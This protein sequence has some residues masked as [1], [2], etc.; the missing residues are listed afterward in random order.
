MD[1]IDVEKIVGG[2]LSHEDIEKLDKEL[3]EEQKAEVVQKATGDFKETLKSLS[4]LR[5]EKNRIETKTKELDEKA[6][7]V[8]DKVSQ[9]RNEQVQKAKD[10]FKTEFGL[11]DEEFSKVEETFKRTDEGHVDADFV[12]DNLKRTYAYLNPDTLLKAKSEQD[13]MAKN[14]NN[15]NASEAGSHSAKPS[16]GQEIKKF[17][18]AAV[19]LA[20]Q[21]GITPE[22]A[23][24]QIS[25]GMSRKLM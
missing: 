25:Q 1:K 4:A 22:Q 13:R 3:T 7:T 11:T 15:A 16:D 8:D 24:K 19:S 20:K 17:S 5:K 10:R 23:E 12:F 21:A 18:D 14:A 2:E 6:K 9:F